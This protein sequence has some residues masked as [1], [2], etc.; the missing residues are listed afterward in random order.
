M[1]H[2]D[3]LDR[4]RS[5]IGQGAVYRLGR[6]GYAPGAPLPFGPTRECDCSGFVCWC[7]RISRHVF[8]G[9]RLYGVYDHEWVS[10]STIVQDALSA[11]PGAFLRLAWPQ[12]RPGDLLVYAGKPVGHVGVVGEVDA[13]GPVTVVHC[14]SG[15]FRRTND[16]IRETGVDK[17]AFWHLRG[18]I[19]VRPSWV[20]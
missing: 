7:L 3:V 19:V 9:H 17:D 8:E 5:A 10:T 15:N 4:A 16:A 18:A 12:A 1:T 20:A 6:G 11:S 13:N 2:A 14:S